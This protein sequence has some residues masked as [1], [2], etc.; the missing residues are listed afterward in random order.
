MPQISLY[1]DEETFKKVGRA[2]KLEN[3]S[4]SKWVSSRI[5]TSLNNSWPEDWFSLFGSLND[6][7]FKEPNE[8]DINADSKREML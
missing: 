4:I 7:T 3:K 8:L 2:A 6:E 5:K 1:V